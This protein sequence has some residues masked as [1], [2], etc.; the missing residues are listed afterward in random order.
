MEKLWLFLISRLYLDF[1]KLVVGI[2]IAKNGIYS[3]SE[4]ETKCQNMENYAHNTG[5]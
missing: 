1:Y 5:C 2:H 4:K 3:K